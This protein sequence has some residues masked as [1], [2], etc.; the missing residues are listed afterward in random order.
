MYLQKS[1][2]KRFLRTVRRAASG[3]L[4]HARLSERG[5]GRTRWIHRFGFGTVYGLF[6]KAHRIKPDKRVYN[7]LQSFKNY[8]MV[9][10]PIIDSPEYRNGIVGQ[11]DVRKLKSIPESRQ[12]AS[13]FLEQLNKISLSKEQKKEILR[14]FTE[15]RRTATEN[16]A[17]TMKDPFARKEDV[18][19][20][21]EGTGGLFIG[22]ASDIASIC[23]GLNAE[24]RAISRTAFENFTNG[25]DLMDDMKDAAIDYGIVQNSIV[26]ISIKYPGEHKRLQEIA[27]KRRRK[28]SKRWLATNMPRTVEEAAIEFEKYMEKIPK[29]NRTKEIAEAARD[30]FYSF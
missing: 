7:L 29:N 19:R 4:L 26:S 11:F 2:G 3:V 9:L 23:Y 22:T 25:L 8:I 6:L 28:L 20:G 13:G 14:I 18:L 1:R 12:L 17:R 16:I 24:R 27:L 5:L 10:D 30:A 15:F 21:I